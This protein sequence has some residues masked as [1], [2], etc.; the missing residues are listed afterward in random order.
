MTNTFTITL[1]D[2]ELRALEFVALSANDWI[3]NAVHERCRIAIDELVQYEIQSKLSAGLPISGTKE[4]IALASVAPSAAQRNAV[5]E[6]QM[7]AMYSTGGNPAG[8]P[9]VPIEISTP[10]G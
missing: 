7:A 2:L 9:P 1:T 8:E 5:I 10:Q 6:S 4:E 3:Q